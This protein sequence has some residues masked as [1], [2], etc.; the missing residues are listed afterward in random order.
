MVKFMELTRKSNNV[1]AAK[2][3]TKERAEN[4]SD[5]LLPLLFEREGN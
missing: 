2:S 5:T 4:M 3:H 1:Y